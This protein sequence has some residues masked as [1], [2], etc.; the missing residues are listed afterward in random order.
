[1]AVRLTALR[2]G[3]PLP[4]GKF[5]VL[6]EA[7]SPERIKSTE[8]SDGLIGNRARDLPAC[9]I[10]PQPTTLPRDPNKNSH[11]NESKSRRLGLAR[12]FINLR[13]KPV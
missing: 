8:K 9:S 4:S 1:M 11:C 7:E 5:L 3:L 6:I 12:T 13:P 2:A 10:V